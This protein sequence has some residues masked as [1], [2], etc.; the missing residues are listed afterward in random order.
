MKLRHLWRPNSA[1]QLDGGRSKLQGEAIKLFTTHYWASS[2]RRPAS[3]LAGWLAGSAGRALELNEPRPTCFSHPSICRA[4]VS[5]PLMRARCSRRR[6]ARVRRRRRHHR[7]RGRRRRSCCC[8][9]CRCHLLIWSRAAPRTYLLLFPPAEQPNR[10]VGALAY[11]RPLFA[12]AARALVCVIVSGSRGRPKWRRKQG[13]ARR[14]LT[15]RVS[16]ATDIN[17]P[18]RGRRELWRGARRDKKP[19]VGLSSSSAAPLAARCPSRARRVEPNRTD[20][21]DKQNR[22]QE[23]LK[24]REERS[25]E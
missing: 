9:C 1:E 24:G 16:K 6:I 14:R 11:S 12:I 23:R 15:A 22:R 8:C 2:A 19:T 25:D 7:R 21:A 20:S 10:T 4:A 17:Q 18:S 5:W 13:R 3:E